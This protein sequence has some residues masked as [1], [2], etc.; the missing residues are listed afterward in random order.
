VRFD[1]NVPEY[2]YK[3]VREI[4][5]NINNTDGSVPYFSKEALAKYALTLKICLRN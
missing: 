1:R 3:N 5:L 4:V 2:I